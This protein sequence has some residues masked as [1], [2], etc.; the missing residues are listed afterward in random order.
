[1]KETVSELLRVGD[2]IQFQTGGYPPP[3][4]EWEPEVVREIRIVDDDK[5]GTEVESV[6]WRHIRDYIC[7]VV[8]VGTNHWA[9]NDQIRKL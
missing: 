4:C 3:P 9:R 7:L 6:E 5:E 8:V 1:M 2:V